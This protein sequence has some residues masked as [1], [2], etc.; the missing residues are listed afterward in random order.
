MKQTPTAPPAADSFQHPLRT[1][2]VD[3][4]VV[5]LESL[6]AYFKTQPLFQVVGTAIDGGEALQM[7]ELLGPDLV[8]MDLHMPVVDGFQ[9]T[10]ILRRRAPN[11]R[12]IIMTVEA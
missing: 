9:A 1:L 4:S 5:V 2:V 11:I 6:C 7:A 8:L 10:A 12:I 3:D